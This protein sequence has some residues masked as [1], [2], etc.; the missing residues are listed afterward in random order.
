MKS[1]PCQTKEWASKQSRDDNSH[2]ETEPRHQHKHRVFSGF[3]DKNIVFPV[4]IIVKTSTF[5]L[6]GTKT[7]LLFS[8]S[9]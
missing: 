8:S 5:Y 1:G 9:L 6:E 4:K 3:V 7:R 2:E